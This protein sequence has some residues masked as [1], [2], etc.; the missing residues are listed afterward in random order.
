MSKTRQNIL[1][2]LGV[3]VLTLVSFRVGRIVHDSAG[4][5]A[6]TELFAGAD[7][8]A[9][10]LITKLHPEYK[11]WFAPVWQPPS[12]E[13]ESL[14]FGLQAAIGSGLVFHYLGYHRGRKSKAA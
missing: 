6:K 14:L 9:V 13:I 10:H 7:A 11:P 12:G 4:D 8:N 3:V 2:F 1:L 5:A